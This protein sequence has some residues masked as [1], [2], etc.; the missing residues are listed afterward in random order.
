MC[1][2]CGKREYKITFSEE[3][4]YSLTHGY[5]GI[6]LCRQCYINRIEEAIKSI[7]ENLENQKKLL[8]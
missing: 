2:D 1:K 4:T 6:Q 7:Q 3:P 8:S 5:G